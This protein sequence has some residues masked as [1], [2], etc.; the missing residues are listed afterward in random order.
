[1]AN[2]EKKSEEPEL[3]MLNISILPTPGKVYIR[4]S[5]PVSDIC[6]T[7]PQAIS[8]ATKLKELTE[9]ASTMPAV[10]ADGRDN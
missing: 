5:T 8:F 4:F 10:R 1:M 3:K 7:V 2:D 9:K 6:F